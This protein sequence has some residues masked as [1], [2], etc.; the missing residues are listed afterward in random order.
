MTNNITVLSQH[1]QPSGTTIQLIAH[2]SAIHAACVP[3]TTSIADLAHDWEPRDEPFWRAVLRSLHRLR[4][5]LMP[6]LALA[7]QVWDVPEQGSRSHLQVLLGY[8]DSLIDTAGIAVTAYLPV[9][10][11]RTEPNLK[12]RYAALSTLRT[13]EQAVQETLAVME[14]QS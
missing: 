11:S 9:C 7:Q 5:A 12:K 14:V 10:D 8:A 6:A 2:R 1:H 3:L 4:T 13:L